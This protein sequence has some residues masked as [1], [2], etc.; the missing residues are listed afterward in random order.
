[1]KKLSLVLALILV[2]TC[3]A[4]VA[5][6]DDTD[7]SSADS[8]AASSDASSAASSDASSAASSDAS[9]EDA[10]SDASAEDSSDASAEDSSDESAE[11]SSEPAIDST[12]ATELKG[13]NVA[14]NK[15]YTGGDE[16]TAQQGYNANLTD[17]QASNVGAYDATWFGF[18]YNVGSATP[19]N[20]APNGVGTVVIDLGAKTANI[21]AI[22]VNCYN[23]NNSGIAPADSIVAYVSE[24]GNSYTEVGA[25]V[26]PEGDDPAWASIAVDNASAQYVKL[27][28]TIPGTWT[29]INEIE[30]Y[31]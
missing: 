1:M 30:V 5:C 12:P 19:S 22:R 23:C 14:L 4:F 25:L 21:N 7:T 10:S 11:D 15:P 18:Y 17:G 13:S 29:F 3:F 24:D 8:S 6:G 27:V 2:F 26:L 9:S 31:A 28:F 16:A 20:N